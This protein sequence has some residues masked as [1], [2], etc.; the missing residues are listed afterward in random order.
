MLKPI[1]LW[2]IKN[3][4]F[5]LNYSKGRVR[6]VWCSSNLSQPNCEFQF[7]D[8]NHDLKSELVVIEGDYTLAYEN[9]GMY[10]AVWRWN[11]WGFSNVWRSEKG[12]YKNL[13]IEKVNGE[14]FIVV[15]REIGQADSMV[16]QK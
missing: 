2:S 8:I 11:G 5:I 4:F 12:N 13:M 14:T 16:F 1:V 3:H 10:A 7:A 6:Y 15:D 9:R